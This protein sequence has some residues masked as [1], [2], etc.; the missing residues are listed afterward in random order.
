MNT[1]RLDKL[2]S[3]TGHYTRSAARKLITSGGV[4]VDGIRVFR[5][6]TPVARAAVVI[7]G[8]QRL[9]TSE[10]VYYMLNKPTGY[11]SATEDE[12]YPA[13]TRL[14]PE[15]LQSRGI[16]PVGRLDADVTGLLLLTDDG[17]FAHRVSSPRGYIE[18]CYEAFLDGGLS[19]EDVNRIS[20]GIQL[21]TVCFR[22]ARVEFPDA[23]PSHVILTV[24]EGKYH[25]VKKIFAACG[26][27]VLRLHRLS[28]GGLIL[29]ST[30]KTGAFRAL[31]EEEKTAVLR[32]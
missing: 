7:A 29:D 10:F 1:V 14:F 15:Y 31:R 20:S 12:H 32:S 4:T 11:V 5:P 23:N 25:E 24:T 27:P 8:G 13:V 3:D 22:P 30:L 17:D 28:I 21:E 16:F 18:K 19:T 2:L 9:D 26:H 6:E